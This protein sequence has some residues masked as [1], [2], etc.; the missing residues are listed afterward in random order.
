MFGG[1]VARCGGSGGECSSSSG[2]RRQHAA[3]RAGTDLQLVGQR[4]RGP[5]SH[6]ASQRVHASQSQ[7]AGRRRDRLRRAVSAQTHAAGRLAGGDP[8]DVFQSNRRAEP[9]RLRGDDGGRRDGEASTARQPRLVRGL[10]VCARGSRRGHLQRPPLRCTDGHF[11]R[12]RALL[13]RARLPERG[14]RAAHEQHVVDRLPR[15]VRRA[16]GEGHHADRRRP[17]GRSMDVAAPGLGGHLPGH[18]RRAVLHELLPGAD[19]GQ[20][21]EHGVGAE[22]LRAAP[23]LLGRRHRRQGREPASVVGRLRPGPAGHGGDDDDG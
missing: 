1:D 3:V 21:R 4:R 22:H 20:R 6:G 16:A 19:G 10:A 17:A 11:G 23:E 8:P 2:G 9:R 15:D 18:G 7:R 13:Q 5:G 12:Q 14:H